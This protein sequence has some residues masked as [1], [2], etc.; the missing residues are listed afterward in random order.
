MDLAS[1]QP[2]HSLNV[3]AGRQ[4]SPAASLPS[5]SILPCRQSTSDLPGKAIGQRWC[6]VDRSVDSDSSVSDSEYFDAGQDVDSSDDDYFD[7][8]EGTAL[9]AVP[10]QEIEQTTGDGPWQ[11]VTRR[12]SRRK[13]QHSPVAPSGNGVAGVKSGVQVRHVS[14]SHS[15]SQR[16]TGKNQRRWAPD[17]DPRS[18]L[19]SH[20][21]WPLCV[22]IFARFGTVDWVSFQDCQVKFHQC[23][24]KS[25]T[26]AE[27]L[28]FHRMM[29]EGPQAIRRAD[30][31]VFLVGPLKVMLSKYHFSS[32]AVFLSLIFEDITPGFVKMLGER[33]ITALS[34]VGGKDDELSTAIIE[35]LARIGQRGECWLNRLG[36]QEL[37]SRAR[38]NLF[39][40]I[41]FLFKHGKKPDL[42]RSLHRQVSGPWLEKYHYA[43]V[44]RL[45]CDDVQGDYDGLLRDL[46]ASVRAVLLWLDGRFFVLPGGREDKQLAVCFADIVQSV[47]E[48]MGRR[49]QQPNSLWLAVWLAVAQWSVRFRKLLSNHL[50]FDRTIA[51]LNG[52]LRHIHPR[53]ELE[54]L[55]F[56]LRLLLLGKVLAKCEELLLKR[57]SAL[58]SHAWCQH[59]A[60]LESLLAKCNQFMDHYRPA[61]TVASQSVSAR[62]EKEARLNLLLK[63]S[64]FHR[65]SCEIHRTPRQQIRE[66]MQAYATAHDDGWALSFY[67]LE[68]GTI[69][70]A[71]WY[72][73]AEEGAAAAR[74]L[75]GV[76][77]SLVNLSWKKAE[78]LATHGFYQAAVDEFHHVRRL[79]EDRA[80]WGKRDKIDGRLAMTQFLWFEAENNT[81]HL[82]S[83]YR[84]SVDLLG[85]CSIKDRLC[86]EGALVHIVNAMKNSGLRFE[87]YA[88][89][90]SV[91]GYLV[92][93][94]SGI[95]SWHHFSNLLYIRHKMGL[96][97]ADAVNKL[98][99]EIGDNPH[100]FIGVDK[101]A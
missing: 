15:A 29:T 56:E 3:P 44:R 31:M 73:L 53:Y 98:A 37:T 100:L 34:G 79:T 27:F 75:M 81:D 36:W 40:S 61:F 21:Y 88:R 92:K 57:D 43:T 9:P 55:A 99:D 26:K 101:K 52:V 5:G 82:I 2:S 10:E 71:K 41:A 23:L 76:Q 25:I 35:L 62:H 54:N 42:I 20:S 32:D 12:K 45:S 39:S 50:E 60:M 49:D 85:R 59:E 66:K 28:R 95:R 7:A 58:F 17:S 83:A 96:T 16:V 1:L 19:S 69:E 70:L 30:D 90:T 38:C 67:H 80:D 65:L 33:F 74:S 8:L 68:M 84:L 78:L 87:D 6:L 48:V 51:L 46:R 86:F 22:R 72:F 77:F 47:I 24:R 64:A 97:D 13:R 4:P 89:Q 11:I 14:A 63:E 94:G 93:D 18:L 91:L